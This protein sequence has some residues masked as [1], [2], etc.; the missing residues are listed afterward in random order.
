MV[1]VQIDYDSSR[2]KGVLNTSILSNVR[3]YFS[4]EDKQQVFKRR[5]AVGYRPQTRIYAIT[6][7]G[8]FEPRLL[9][10]ILRYFKN[11]HLSGVTVSINCSPE[12]IDNTRLS[13]VK[14]PLET[15]NIPLR[16]Y[17]REAAE[18]A[19]SAGSGIILLPTSAGKTLVIA[20]ICQTLQKARLGK[21]LILVPDIQLVQQTYSD[22]LEYGIEESN[23]T[24][25]TGGNEP[26]FTKPIIIANSQ[27]LLSKKQDITILK[28]VE[29]LIIDEVHK[30]RAGN[31]INKIIKQI[32]AKYRFGFTGTMPVCQMD[33]WYLNGLIG[34]IVYQKKSH[35]LREQKFISKVNIGVIN[36]RHKD[37]PSFTQA[38][39]LNPTVEYEEE[40]RFLQENIFRNNTIA[41]LV[42][43]LDKNS[44]IMVDRI[45]HGEQLLR[46]LK[47]SITDKHIC[48]VQG[49][50]EIE[51]REKIR[52]LME[53][54]DNVVCIAISK[55][56][57]TGINIKNLHYVVFA[58]IGKAKIKI[59][60]SIGRSLRL[61]ANKKTAYI[62]DIADNLKYSNAH[63][64]ERLKLYDSESI[65]YTI[66]EVIEN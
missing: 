1:T 6:P 4:I 36:L 53:S 44:L 9:P 33:K 61:H 46:V 63:L 18:S 19:L 7:Q 56:F 5:Y 52:Q 12:F 49:S 39:M 50:V 38:T 16:D 27:I 13:G 45:N 26:D 3:E 14:E 29:V 35:E 47:E 20:T 32:T 15:L 21:A 55:I 62:I 51:E 34:D 2:K 22:F 43:K 66:K 48:F 25:W 23:V 42:Q 58:A 10:E 57:S 37:L 17:Q 59:I 40:I 8:R 24:K 65:Q 60:Q 11:L 28:N 30:C 31:S 54:S 41:R 64:E